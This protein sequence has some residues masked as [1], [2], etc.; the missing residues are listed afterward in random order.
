[1]RRDALTQCK[2]RLAKYANSSRHQCLTLC[3]AQCKKY[4][5][6][7]TDSRNNTRSV[8]ISLEMLVIGSTSRSSRI[9]AFTQRKTAKFHGGISLRGEMSLGN[10]P[11][12]LFLRIL[13]NVCESIVEGRTEWEYLDCGW[14]YYATQ[15]RNFSK[16]N[17]VSKSFHTLL[18][19]YVRVDETPVRKKVLD[20]Q[21]LRFTVILEAGQFIASKE[22]H[23]TVHAIKSVCGPVWNNP[24]FRDRNTLTQFFRYPIHMILR[25]GSLAWFRY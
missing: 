4:F 15:L 21:M 22:G 5:I 25:R 23:Y 20:L 6:E 14:F 11:R 13:E 10:V 19:H 12:E 18:T 24:A 16:L 9:Q 17:L 3:P 7:S 8:S 2:L 1:M